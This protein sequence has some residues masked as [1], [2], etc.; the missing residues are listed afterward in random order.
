MARLEGSLFAL[1]FDLSLHDE[2]ITIVSRKRTHADPAS[3]ASA[4]ATSRSWFTHFAL[5]PIECPIS[6]EVWLRV[7]PQSHHHAE[8]PHH[9]GETHSSALH[10]APPPLL[11]LIAQYCSNTY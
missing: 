1:K 8:K 9:R 4:T 7:L 5:F 2:R 10:S 11:C 6:S 3:P